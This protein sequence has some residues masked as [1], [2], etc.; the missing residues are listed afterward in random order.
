M[1]NMRQKT[2]ACLLALSLLVSGA[3]VVRQA[4]A[5]LTSRA[6]TSGYV[7]LDLTDTWTRLEDQVANWQKKIAVTN[8]GDADCEVRVKMF[9]GSKYAPYITYSS[10]SARWS[11]KSDGYWYYDGI[12]E[13]G[14]T[15]AELL[16]GI[17]RE[18]FSRD[19]KPGETDDFNIIAVHEY[20]RVQYDDSGNG[21]VDWN[22]KV[23]ID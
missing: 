20:A 4:Q 5:Y 17:D 22:E 18:A 16:A 3:A 1:R 10:N 23:V 11:L 7:T 2:A 15:T 9:V 12:L 19:F 21:F 13:P 14:D 6:G 8:T